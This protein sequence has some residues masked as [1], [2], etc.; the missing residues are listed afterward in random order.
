RYLYNDTGAT[1][2]A[3]R[4]LARGLR[5]TLDFG[6]IYGLLPL[7]LNRWDPL[8][9]WSIWVCVVGLALGLARFVSTAKVGPVGVVLILL[10]TPDLLQSF[11]IALVQAVE[12]VL[13]VHALAC[14]AKGRRPEA[15][16]IATVLLFVKPSMAYVYGFLIIISQ[17]FD[18]PPRWRR[19]LW[20]SLVAGGALTAWLGWRFGPGPLVTTLWPGAGM[21]VY[22]E[23]H[24]G[25]FFGE[26]RSFW[27]IP[28]GTLRDYLR[29]EVGAWIAGTAVLTAGGAASLDRLIRSKDG[30]TVDEVVVT[31]A[32][33]HLS[34]VTFFYGQRLSWVYYYVVLICGLAAMTGPGRGRWRSVAV[35]VV[36]L[37]T[38][39][40][41]KAKVEETVRL[42]R[43]VVPAGQ[44]GLA[45]VMATPGELAEWLKVKEL[46][47]ERGPAALLA[48]TEGAAA[49]EP[50]LFLDP[51]TLYLVPGHPTPSE[52]QR[53]ADQIAR[54]NTVV[55]VRPKGDTTRGGFERWPE[56]AEALKPFLTVWEGE[57]Y[58]VAQ[59]LD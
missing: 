28:N 25:F 27:W 54:A 8:G 53:K 37:L 10:A 31:C 44:V 18:R 19:A 38:L 57:F 4:L 6:Y 14:Q 40:G 39:V 55:R 58:E 2:V 59:R 50:R 52:I 43:E 51:E 1:L 22:R 32:I 56:I 24:Y 41:S 36:A 9:R 33:M 46:A 5:P 21:E 48:R 11:G 7:E 17:A 47:A 3:P 34:F 12:P 26:G 30:S 42:W 13:L 35:G 49:L 29:Y 20:P 16:A 23:N 15:L 45:G